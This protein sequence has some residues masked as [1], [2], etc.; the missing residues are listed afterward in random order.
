M[1]HRKIPFCLEQ[2]AVVATSKRPTIDLSE[3]NLTVSRRVRAAFD[4]AK[5]FVAKCTYADIHHRTES[6]EGKKG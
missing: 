3:E 4:K 1:T 2:F 6:V 5:H